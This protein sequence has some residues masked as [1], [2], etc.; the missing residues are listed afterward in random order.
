MSKPKHLYI[1]IPFCNSICKYCDFVRFIS[2]D[3]IKEKY[4]DIIIN[5]IN[6]LNW[7]FNSIYIGGGTPNSLNNQLLSKLLFSLQKLIN[8]KTEFTIECNPECISNEQIILFKKYKVN[9]VSVGVQTLNQDILTKYNRKHTNLQIINAID[10]F[11][12]NGIKNISCDFIYGF[13]EQTNEDLLDCIDFIYKHKISHFSFYSL[14]VKDNSILKKENYKLNDN[15]IQD[16]FE[17]IINN[18]NS[19]YN[20]YEISNWS[21]SKKTES[22]HNKC[23]WKTDDWIGIGLGASGLEN[24]ILYTNIGNFDNWKKNE[25]K[26][27]KKDYYFQILMMGLRLKEGIDLSIKKNKDAFNFFKDKIKDSLCIKNNFLYAPNINL[28]NNILID[29]ED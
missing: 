2:N 24:K 6:K 26:L 8:K 14:E 29:I 27:S 5:E 15:K 23:Y 3:E 7:K 21:I 16:M 28:I 12:K 11:K 17:F 18:I 9:R 22:I 19:T 20:R 13:N 1:H 25:I 10:L 4:I